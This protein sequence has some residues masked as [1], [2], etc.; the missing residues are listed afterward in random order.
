MIFT[1]NG[2][3]DLAWWISMALGI[4]AAL[5]CAPINEK[6][7]PRGAPALAPIPAR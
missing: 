2:S 4:F 7:L 5:V 3:Y 1:R 6:P